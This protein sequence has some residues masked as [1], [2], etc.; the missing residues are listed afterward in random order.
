MDFKRLS[1]KARDL[2][3][4][5][6]GTG[7][8]KEDAAELRKIAKGPGGIKDKARSAAEALK[9]PGAEQ[10]SDVGERVQEAT[11]KPSPRDDAPAR[12]AREGSGGS[13][14]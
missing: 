1:G 7:N 13:A 8:L 5:R 2:V 9:K 4:K 3:E 6:G 12:E 11:P 14:V 10:G